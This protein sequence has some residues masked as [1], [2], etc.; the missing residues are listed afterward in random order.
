MAD[1][2]A[3]P[4]ASRQSSVSEPRATSQE[5]L[6]EPDTQPDWYW[7]W[8]VFSAGCSLDECERIRQLDR[9][10]IF[11]HLLAAADAGR[12][13]SGSW[14]LTAAQQAELAE[15][16]E[17]AEADDPT[18]LEPSMDVRQLQIWRRFHSATQ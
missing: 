6:D 11:D 16:A 15:L 13:V 2:P 8:K 3:R 4:D 10:T 9:S 12:E 14:V 7:T 17:Q 1:P 5:P 18:E